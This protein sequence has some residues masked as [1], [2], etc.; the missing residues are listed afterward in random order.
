M[1]GLELRTAS[2]HAIGIA[3]KFEMTGAM[4][5]HALRRQLHQPRDTYES[6]K[7][8]E[9]MAEYKAVTSVSRYRLN[10][11]VKLQSGNRIS[12]S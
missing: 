6:H 7:S 5:T 4:M 3:V 1:Q 12:Q 11:K 10:C 2:L 8:P 9:L